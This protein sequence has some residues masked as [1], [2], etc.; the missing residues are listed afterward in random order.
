MFQGLGLSS[1]WWNARIRAVECQNQSGGMPES[2]RW[3]ARI[4]MVECQKQSGGMPEAEWWNARIKLVECQN[5][6]DGMPEQLAPAS[7]SYHQL[8]LAS[9]S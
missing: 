3:N 1:D 5:Q 2:E 4:R 7:P 9:P 6:I 8:A